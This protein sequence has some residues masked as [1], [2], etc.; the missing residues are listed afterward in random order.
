MH[1]GILALVLEGYEITDSPVRRGLEAVERFA[2]QDEG[3][4]RIQAC[5]SPVWDTVLTIIAL[6]DAGLPTTHPNV[7]TATSWLQSHQLLGPEGDWR[8]YSP[9]TPPGGFSFE[10]YN[11]WYPDVDDTAAVILAFLKQDPASASSPHVIR[12]AEWILGMQNGDGGWPA[13]DIDND[14]L[15]MN[16]IPSVTWVLC[17]TPPP[18]TLPDESLRLLGF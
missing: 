14:K 3:G 8:A 10:Y 13:F 6:C 9:S 4:K 12:A 17:V 15:Y 5:V 2:W 16:E 1:L 18:R 11:A 7:K